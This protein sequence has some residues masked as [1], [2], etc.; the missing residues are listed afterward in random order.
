MAFRINQEG[1][2]MQRPNEVLERLHN[3]MNQHDLDAFVA[4][5]D[6]D[7]KSDQPAHPNR[8]FASRDQ[9]R[10]NWATMFEGIPDF[11]AELLSQAEHGDV[12]WAEWRWR[13]TRQDRPPLDVRGVTLFG[14]RDGRIVWGRLYMEETEAAG[15]DIDETMRHLTM[16]QPQRTEPVE[17]EGR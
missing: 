8:G 2:M 11:H 1:T 9:V 5:F 13:G 15:A 16:R 4:C 17:A 10:K 7:Y 6:A 12:A 14:V 3:A